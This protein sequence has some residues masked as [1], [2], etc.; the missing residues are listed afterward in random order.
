MSVKDFY[1]EENNKALRSYKE[2]L[3]V[4]RKINEETENLNIN[5]YNKFFN[6]VSKSILKMADLEAKIDEDYFKSKTFEQLLEENNKLYEEMLP[7][8]YE[9]SFANPSFCVKEFGNEIG[10]ILCYIYSRVRG[11]I[12]FAF[13][14]KI[15]KME[16][17]NRL[18]IDV[19]NYL[20]DKK[21]SKELKNILKKYV[22]EDLNKDFKQYI[23][24][25]FSKDYTYYTD[26]TCNSDLNDL[27]YLFKYGK[28]I[29]ENEIKTAKFL[30]DYSDDKLNV[31]AQMIVKAYIEG[32]KR[33][34]K[35]ITLRSNVRI[36]ANAGQEKITKG[37]IEHLRKN[38]LYGYVAEVV[39]TDYNKQYDYDHKFDN[40]LYLDEEF[41]KLSNKAFETEAEKNK[42]ILKD[43]SGIILIERFGEEPFSPKSKEERLT[44][45]ENQ[46]SI[47]QTIQ[48]ERRQ[49]IE[50]YIPE[51]ERSFCIIAFP[52]PEIGEN[53]EEI[54]EDILKV[55]MLD[56]EKYEVIQQV[57]IDTLDKGKYVHIKGRGDNETDIKVHLHK[58]NN[59]EKET[60]FVN[61]VADVNIPVGEV[62]TSPVLKETSGILHVKEI[63]LRGFKYNNLKLKFED[64]YITDYTCTNFENEEENKKYIREN[65]LFPHKT[66]PIGEFA[67]GT[68][69]FAYVIAKKHNI[70][71][72]LPILIIEKMGPHFAVGDTCFAWSEDN[73]VYNFLDK[74]EIIARDNEKSILRKTD[75]S[76]AYTNCHTDITLPYDSLE[77]ISVITEYGEE[78]DIIRNGRFVLKG[79][80]ELNKPF[81]EM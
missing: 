35:D 79:T 49:L 73:P 74:K 21:D 25:T 47:Y 80:E 13:T 44:L 1:I 40:A 28:Y 5:K 67:I 52:T 64:G 51:N 56:S 41:A 4:I 9:F 78:I 55:N 26:I 24:E 59:P 37:V 38:N 7:A 77:K 76:K 58:I 70:T 71:N 68:N 33:D 29:T 3:E 65:L 43:Y 46:Q 45:S 48:N 8:K 54:F 11:Y 10:Q 61:C 75:V 27:R 23:Y 31:L 12:S 22:T 66:L 16:K 60:N 81:E 53:F 15:F 30:N 14:H 19:Y 63:Y 2:T 62:F 32:F 17:N 20:K 34:N 57:I 18:F 36:V 50:K 39:S 69:T 72:K 6:Y 42:E